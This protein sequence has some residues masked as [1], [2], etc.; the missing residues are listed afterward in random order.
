MSTA[1]ASSRLEK[2]RASGLVV[3]VSRR[4]S[5]GKFERGG[6]CVAEAELTDSFFVLRDE[7]KRGGSHDGA[8]GDTA[9]A[10]EKLG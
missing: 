7:V 10:K 4:G 8:D 3:G 1:L 5:V 2:G 6:T 9:N